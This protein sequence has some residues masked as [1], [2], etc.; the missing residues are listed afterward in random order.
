MSSCDVVEED[1]S[2]NLWSSGEHHAQE[3]MENI[4]KAVPKAVLENN[5]GHTKYWHFES[6]L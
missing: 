6:N 4:P 1:S 2:G 3:G 5:G